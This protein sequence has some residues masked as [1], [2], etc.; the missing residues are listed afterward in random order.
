MRDDEF[1]LTAR[2]NLK[3]LVIVS[4]NPKTC[5][6]SPQQFAP[7]FQICRGAQMEPEFEPAL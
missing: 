7:D 4:G 6:L 2:H 1:E 3:L 5:R